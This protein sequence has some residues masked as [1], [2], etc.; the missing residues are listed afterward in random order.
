MLKIFSKYLSD[1]ETDTIM[2]DDNF[3]RKM[4]DTEIA[5]AKAQAMQ[6]IMP[7]D[8]SYEIQKTLN[9]LTIN[10]E[11][12][13]E[14]TLQNGIPTIGLLENIKPHL[15]KEA[16]HYIHWGATSQ[17][18]VDTAFVL[19]Y[20]DVIALFKKRLNGIITN[21]QQQEK[22][23]QNL[24]TVA[25]TRTQQAVPINYSDKFKNWY[26][27][28][29]RHIQRLSQLEQRLL[30]VQL[31]GA[32][33]NLSVLGKQGLK[34][35]ELM[36]EELNLFENGIWHSQRDTIVEFSSWMALTA[37]SIAKMAQDILLLSQTELGEIIENASG[38]GKSSTMPHKNNPI[39]SEAIVSLSKFISGLAG[40]NFN[41]LTHQHERDGISWML[42]WQIMPNCINALGTILNHAL[43]ISTHLKIKEQN[44]TQ[45]MS[46]LNG[47]IHS[48]K[49][50]FIL[51]EYNLTRKEAK[52]IVNQ[53]CKLVIDN[54]IHFTEALTQLTSDLNIN[55]KTIL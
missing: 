11:D 29:D 21:L 3:I 4:L 40:T 16:Q 44:V 15:S 34:V 14:S 26:L 36:A 50:S 8:T 24:Q 39:L 46:L 49:A 20:K 23:Y 22:T 27:P 53:A 9:E 54:N 47:L 41:A 6:G 31:G 42:E 7:S 17:D 12:L 25:R 48:E 2:S 35:R 1:S 10:P 45:N 13:V 32:G 38:G 5:L 28:L 19:M 51:T 37:G 18:I 43:T 52:T 33:G 55:W 30:S